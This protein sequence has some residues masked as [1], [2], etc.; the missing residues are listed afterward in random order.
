MIMVSTTPSGLMQI[1][2]NSTNSSRLTIA[3]TVVAG[4]RFSYSVFTLG[5]FPL[6]EDLVSFLGVV[7][8]LEAAADALLVC[9]V[10]F[11]AIYKN[12]LMPSN[13]G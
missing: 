5:F 8:F 6:L 2:R 1:T 7:F 10:F 13:S 11:F 12:L 4:I 9:F 3:V